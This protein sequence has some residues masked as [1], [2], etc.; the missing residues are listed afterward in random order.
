M[1][2]S[3]FAMKLPRMSAP[4]SFFWGVRLAFW[5]AFSLALTSGL[6]GCGGGGGSSTDS[7][8]PAPVPNANSTYGLNLPRAGLVASDLAV[9]VAEGDVLGEAI[10][11][12]YLS[13]RNV[14][15]TNLIRVK[16]PTKADAISATD[17]AT[18]KAEIDAKLPAGIQAQ[19]LTWTAPSRVVGSCAMGIT[20]ALAFGYDPKY[21][22]PNAACLNTQASPLY[23]SE[24]RSP[25]ADHQI[26]PAM[27]L[28]ARSLDAA[29]ALIDRGLKADGSQPQGDGYL[30]NTS[31]GFRNTRAVDFRVLPDS[32]AGRLKLI[33][34]DNSAGGSKDIVENQAGLLF[35]F[36]GLP[37]T[38]G[39]T[40][41]SYLPGAV[42]DSLTSYA[43]QLPDARGQTTVLKWLDAGLTGSYGTVEEPCN[44]NQKFPKASVLIDQYYR[45]ASLIEAYWKSLQSPGQGLFVGE[46]LARPFADAPSFKLEGSQYLISSRALRPAATY[47][48]DYQIGAAGS[49]ITLASFKPTKAEIQNLS[50]PLPPATATALRWRGPCPTQSSQQCTLASSP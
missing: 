12:Y 43:A 7:A 27:M 32:W 21:C 46:P 49:W 1:K 17:F 38:P 22:V 6:S 50:S 26:R 29:K 39:L 41:N 44:F 13:A 25:W 31:D 33:Y 23:D 34:Q 19:L 28:G 20:S 47:T 35:Y 15:A 36:T 5:V 30:L 8:P 45:G 40:S 10:A 4:P 42:G 24:S 48:L 11:A 9:L 3:A 14:P 16:L 18:L 37:I 2:V